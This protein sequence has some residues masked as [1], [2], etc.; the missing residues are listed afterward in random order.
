MER[1]EVYCVWCNWWVAAGRPFRAPRKLERD[2]INHAETFCMWSMADGR[3]IDY[4]FGHLG[5]AGFIACI[6]V[7]G[8]PKAASPAPNRPCMLVSRRFNTSG[9]HI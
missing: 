7:G 9:S 4:D 5:A 2:Q 6:L 3:P 8:R 1:G